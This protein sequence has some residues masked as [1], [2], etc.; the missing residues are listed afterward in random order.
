MNL[1]KPDTQSEQHLPAWL[2]I[3]LLLDFQLA[4]L[5]SWCQLKL[6]VHIVKKDVHMQSGT[7]ITKCNV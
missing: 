4:F 5:I 6:K 2:Y 1:G 7:T 3:A